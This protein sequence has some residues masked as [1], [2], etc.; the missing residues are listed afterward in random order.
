MQSKTCALPSFLSLWTETCFFLFNILCLGFVSSGTCSS[1]LL[2]FAINLHSYTTIYKFSIHGPCPFVLFLTSLCIFFLCTH[3]SM[4]LY[5]ISEVKAYFT[6]LFIVILFSKMVEPNT[7]TCR[8][9]FIF[10]LH[11]PI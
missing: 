4:S 3:A 11:L 1:D 9:C 2:M 6:F 8:L 7:P 10:K 5:H